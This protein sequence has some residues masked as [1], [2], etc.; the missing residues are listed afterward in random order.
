[1][2]FDSGQEELFSGPVFGLLA[3]IFSGYRVLFHGR[4]QPGR[5]ADH[6]HR[7][8]DGV[9]VRVAFMSAGCSMHEPQQTFSALW[10]RFNCVN[11]KNLIGP[12]YSSLN[13]DKWQLI[14]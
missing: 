6:S 4:K 8:S 5:E 7:C 14:I 1:V 2:W 9:N 12:I 10:G 13:L 3:L 11:Y